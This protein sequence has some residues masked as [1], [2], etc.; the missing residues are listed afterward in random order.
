MYVFK[1]DWS[2][3]F[4][5]SSCVHREHV[6]L[7]HVTTYL[8]TLWQKWCVFALGGQ[9]RQE[10]WRYNKQRATTIQDPFFCL[11]IELHQGCIADI[12]P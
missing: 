10:D 6:G 8:S 9:S 1:D 12:I 2:V 11:P 3:L 4:V 5:P 7:Q